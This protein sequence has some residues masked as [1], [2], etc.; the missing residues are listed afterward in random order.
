MSVRWGAC[1]IES[2]Q[3]FKN[4]VLLGLLG[5]DY[6]AVISNIC[7]LPRKM[8]KGEKERMGGMMSTDIC[9][10]AYEQGR[11]AA[12]QFTGDVSREKNP[13]PVGSVK[14]KSWNRGWNSYFAKGWKGWAEVEQ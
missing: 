1:D 4:C 10:T 8:Y 3:R 13:Y 14:W 2:Q 5:K 11:Y 7:L 9:W 6:E 12:K